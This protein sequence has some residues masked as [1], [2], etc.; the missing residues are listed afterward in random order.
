MNNLRE[1]ILAIDDLKPEEVDVTAEWGHKLYVRMMTPDEYDDW[2]RAPAHSREMLVALV[3]TDEAGDRIFAPGKWE[4]NGD[5]KREFQPGDEATLATRKGH[6]AIHKLF[7]K[8]AAINKL[9]LTPA[10]TPTPANDAGDAA[11]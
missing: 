1:A 2:I 4:A 3:T 7:L 6:A 11:A 5:G 10:K 9:T 8:A